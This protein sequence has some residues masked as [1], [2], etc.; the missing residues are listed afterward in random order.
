MDLLED[1]I[2]ELSKTYQKIWY[3]ADGV[4]SMFSDVTLVKELYELMDRYE[5]FNIYVD[6]AHGMSWAGENRRGYF[7]S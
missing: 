2:T 3:K 7:L 4:Y 1:K 5:Q 6:D